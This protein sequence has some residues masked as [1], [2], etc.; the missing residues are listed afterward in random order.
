MEN[1][2]YRYLTEKRKR[3]EQVGYTRQL[4]SRDFNI[5]SKRI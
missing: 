3:L 2:A 1:M 4:P 5:D